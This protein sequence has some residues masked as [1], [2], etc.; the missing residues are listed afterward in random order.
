MPCGVNACFENVSDFDF[1]LMLVLLL[2][3]V[4]LPS[5]FRKAKMKDRIAS[6]ADLEKAFETA[7]ELVMALTCLGLPG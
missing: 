5:V 1:D 3:F 6:W 7:T 4:L 2:A